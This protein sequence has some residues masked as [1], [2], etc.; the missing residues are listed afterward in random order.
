MFRFFPGLRADAVVVACIAA[1]FA[2]PRLMAQ[3][4]PELRH[5]VVVGDTL[6]RLAHRFMEQPRRYREIAR[7]NGLGNQDLIN[8]GQMLRFPAPYLKMQSGEA[9]I[10]S[11]KGFASVG[12]KAAEVGARA[13]PATDLLTGPD[14]QLTLRLPD[15]SEIRLQPDTSARLTEVKRN[16]ASGAR[17]VEVN[18]SRGRL[19]TDVAPGKADNS[20]FTIRTP[21]A[22]LGVRGTSFR[23]AAQDNSAS[24]EVLEGRVQAAVANA[25]VDVN[26]GF[27]TRATAGKAPLKP[28]PLLPAPSLSPLAAQV[29]SD[30]PELTFASVAGAIRYRALVAEDERFE[31][32]VSDGTGDAPA[33]K[34]PTL[35]DGVYYFRAR[36]IDPQGLEGFNADGR[37]RVRTNPRPPRIIEPAPGGALVQPDLAKIDL[38]FRWEP[39]ADA[40]GGYLLQLAEDAGFT[41]GLREHKSARPGYKLP[42]D[43]SPQRVVYWRV[44]SVDGAGET[45][46]AGTTQVFEMGMRPQ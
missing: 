23:A 9:T 3:V 33:L 13:G 14:G 7:L 43:A 31:R 8:P 12:G 25:A 22:S 6:E 19:E 17:S 45:A 36:A 1:L 18:L 38:M 46:P 35:R 32:I 21:A 11:T 40:A 2:S 5:Q 10:S 27:G 44:R 28:I 15:G 20:R 41:R 4:E 16:P 29:D 39:V 26:R 42:M 34:T 37:F 30:T 24:T